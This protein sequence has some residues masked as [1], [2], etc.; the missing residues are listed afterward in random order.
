MPLRSSPRSAPATK[1]SLSP[2][3]SASSKCSASLSSSPSS[4]S[5]SVEKFLLWLAPSPWARSC[6]SLLVWWL[7]THRT[8]KQRPSTP[9][10]QLASQWSISKHSRSTCPG[11]HYVGSSKSYLNPKR[12]LAL[13]SPHSIGEIFPNRIREIGVATGA[14][15]QWLWN[16]VMSQITPHA[17][18]NIGW[19]E[20]SS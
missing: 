18:A 13:T 10:V 14:G 2:A 1:H 11:A 20:Y 4:S 3:F 16:F 19:S 9:T 6:S 8:R 15:S 7:L 17:I 12:S 5:A